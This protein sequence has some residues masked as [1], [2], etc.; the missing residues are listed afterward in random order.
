MLD[1]TSLQEGGSGGAEHFAVFHKDPSER[2]ISPRPGE[3]V[4]NGDKKG[5]ALAWRNTLIL[6]HID[7][8]LLAFF[9]R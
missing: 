1:A 5:K 7:R 3:N 9:I 4:A 6:A 8:V 2:Q